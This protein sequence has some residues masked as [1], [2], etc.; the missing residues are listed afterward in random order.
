MV[1]EDKSVQDITKTGKDQGSSAEKSGPDGFGG[2]EKKSIIPRQVPSPVKE[3]TANIGR[4]RAPSLRWEYPEWNLGE[5]GRIIDTEALARR[6]IKN[7]KNLFLK[8][9]FDFVGADPKR[10]RYIKTRLKQMATATN[11]PFYVLL[12]QTVSSLIRQSNAFWVKVRNEKASGGQIRKTPEGGKRSPVAGYF[13]LPAETI[14]IKRDEF[15]KVKEYEQCIAGKVAKSFRPHNV[16]HFHLE[17]REGFSVGTPDLVAVKDDIR[18]LRRIEE[19]VELLV[20]NHL[21][22]LFHYQVGTDDKPAAVF[23]DGTT[24]VQVV[25]REIARMPSDGCWVTPERHSVN[26][27]GAG[28]KTVAVEKILEHFKKRVIVGLGNSMVDMGEGDS[29]NRSTAQTMSRNLVDDVKEAQKEFAAQFYMHVIEELLMES[30]F[31][32]NNLYEEDNRVHLQFSEIDIEARQAKENHAVDL[33]LKNAITHTELRELIGKD[34]FE[35]EA[36]PTR[37][38]GKGDWAETNHGLVERDKIILQSMDEP[39]TT[40][41]RVESKSRSTT[42]KTKSSGGNSVQNKNKPANQHGTRSSAKTNKDTSVLLLTNNEIFKTLEAISLKDG[43]MNP[44]ALSKTIDFA[45]ARA[46]ERMASSLR[47]MFKTGVNDVSRPG[48]KLVDIINCWKEINFYLDKRIDVYKKHFISLLEKTIIGKE[49]FLQQDLKSL[50]TLKYLMDR[51]ALTITE[52]EAKRA[53]VYGVLMGHRVANYSLSISFDTA[54]CKK[55]DMD[56]FVYENTNDIIYE[57]LPPLRP[58]CTCKVEKTNWR[59]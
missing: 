50:N 14:H 26:V 49:A 34:P 24:E 21:F 58:G 20:Y 15:G 8:E 44:K 9:G 31:P 18:A 7:K 47:F 4:G 35:G 36:W 48:D 52:D 56:S 54:F 23:P 39:G 5:T 1:D 17:K 33:F 41:S 25:Q 59:N 13:A 30:T 45:F 11:V 10:I 51:K 16:I 37:F 40:E 6:A 29:A 53:Y 38:G 19:N 32:N 55:C 3:Y 22:P 46:K 12:S 42:A 57:E 2:I 43:Y 28:S 27:L